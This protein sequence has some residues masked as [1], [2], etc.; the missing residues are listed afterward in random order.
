MCGT[1]LQAACHSLDSV[2]QAAQPGDVLRLNPAAAAYRLSCV[3]SPGHG[4]VL[5]SLTITALNNGSADRPTIGCE[6]PAADAATTASRCAL[7]LDNVTLIDVDLQV[8][9]CHVTILGSRLVESTVYT[10]RTCRSVRMRVTRSNWTFAGHLPCGRMAPQSN[11]SGEVCRQTPL[12][13]RLQCVSVDVTLDRVRLVLGS[14]VIQSRYSTHVYVVQS[15]FTGD[16]D[17]P[18]SQF[19]GGLRLTFSTIGANITIVNCVFS[20]QVS[21]GLSTTDI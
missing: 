11:V 19:L 1:S 7:R 18:G 6:A 15:Q 10:T 17:K 14:L 13:N 4:Y 9:N 8:D 12:I 2:V 16:S 5:Q 21:T 3:S 20:N